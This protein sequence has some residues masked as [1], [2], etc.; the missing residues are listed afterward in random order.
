MKQQE[1]TQLLGQLGQGDPTAL[2]RL[3]FIVLDELHRLALLPTDNWRIAV[4]LQLLGEARLT[5]GQAERAEALL[6]EAWRILMLTPDLHPEPVEQTRKLL[7][8][9]YEDSNRPDMAD[10]YRS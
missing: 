4:S 6:I 1:V 9:L 3:V 8:A 7:I 5:L 2:D 10:R